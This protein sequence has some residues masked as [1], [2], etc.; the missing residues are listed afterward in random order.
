MRNW[1]KLLS[2]LIIFS[3]IIISNGCKESTTEPEKKINEVEVLLNYL[4]NEG[5]DY[6]NSQACPALISASE[7][8]TYL[9]TKPD[10]IY[11][12]DVRDTVTFI[13]VGHI[14][15]AHNVQIPDVL[16]HIKTLNTVNY[17]KIVIVCYA[18]QSAGYVTGLLRLMGYNNV[19]SLKY[20]MSSWAEVFAQKYWLANI[21][22]SR[23]AQF[24]T[25]PA[26]KNAAGNLPT[27]NT[28]KTD[29]K[30]ILEARVQTLLAA[31]WDPAKISHSGVFSNLSGYYIVNYW[32]LD[33]Y[34]QGHIPGA[35]QYTPR[36]D[37]KSSTYLKTLPTDKPVVVYC[38]SGQGSAQVVAFLRVLGYDA[39]S[40]I[41]G[42]NAM[43]YDNMPGTKFNPN[44]DIMNYP[45]VTG[46]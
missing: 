35:V 2:L 19:Y 41:Y 8:Y 26:N 25:T 16:N 7:V 1:K 37:L 43:N 44:T 31:G 14:Q 34:N 42:V 4:E 5:G 28:G 33:H 46:P 30:E 21:G 29:P 17:E 13:N 3:L 12:I 9:Q 10:K 27:I 18:G 23:A 11:I 45:Y 15:N 20:G 24:V 40:L 22:N 6:I 36:A 38:Y 39:K 32:P